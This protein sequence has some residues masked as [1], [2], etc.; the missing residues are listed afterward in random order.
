[1][2]GAAHSLWFLTITGRQCK[3]PP[4][5]GGSSKENKRKVVRQLAKLQQNLKLAPLSA[6]WR[7]RRL[8]QTR[9]LPCRLVW[10]PDIITDSGTSWARGTLNLGILCICHWHFSSWSTWSVQF[11]AYIKSW[12]LE[13]SWF[14]D[15][16]SEGGLALNKSQLRV[17]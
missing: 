1:M 16:G 2:S 5:R 9:V 7:I 12:L 3:H 14:L 8:R 15:P 17:L 11:E 10:C 4:I 13:L 6:V